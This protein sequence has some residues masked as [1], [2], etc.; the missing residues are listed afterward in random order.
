MKDQLSLFD[1]PPGTKLHEY[2]MSLERIENELLK[3]GLTHNQAKVFIYL[4]KYGS[5][6]A[7]EV[8]NA[9]N[10]HR[11]E[12]YNILHTL[13]NKGIVT[14]EMVHPARFSA[15]SMDKAILTMVN[16]EKERVKTLEKNEKEFVD[17]WDKIP[18]FMVETQETKFEKLQMLQG[19]NSIDTKI[20]EMISDAK[21]EFLILGSEKDISR[22]YHS[23]FIKSLND[24][25]LD[26]KLIISPAQKIPHFLEEV[27][28]TRVKI[29]PNS[30]TENQCFIVKD[31][32]EVIIFL[33]N[34]NHPSR[35]VFA[36]WAE[37]RS[38]IDSMRT[39]FDYSWEN[40]ETIY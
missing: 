13:Q 30:K 34:A 35:S 1:S 29:M 39:L 9:L 3:Y 10:I 38:M 17:V 19:T 5:K 23:D 37:S 22:F 14:A 16:A 18:S 21:E 36:I 24:S 7:P 11:T 8:C 2:K 12:T 6:T 15:I 27:D 25:S 31:S 20:K 32:D 4:G 33:R 28:K 40:S 26:F